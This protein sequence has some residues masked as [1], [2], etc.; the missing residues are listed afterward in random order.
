MD[1]IFIFLLGFLMSFNNNKQISILFIGNSFTY[2]NEM[3]TIFQEI[4]RSKGKDVYVEHCTQG[5]AT[6]LIQSNREEV[7]QSIASRK[8]D[9]I[10]IQGSSR[11]LLKNSS[12]LANKS[13]PALKKILRTIDKTNPNAKKLF[14]M[15]WAYHKGYKPHK[16]ADTYPKMTQKVKRGYLMLKNMFDIDIIPVGIAWYNLRQNNKKIKLYVKDG[17]HPSL[18]GSYL[19]ACCFYSGI[20]GDDATGSKYFSKLGPK[21]CRTLQR[22]ASS[23]V[24]G[25]QKRYGLN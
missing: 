2:R 5:K 20:F 18:K 24:L 10:V 7:H 21:T 16:E 23:T 12:A 19:A 13:I 4:A 3:P 1:L 25:Q 11:D 9:Y 8:W 14:F 17:A 22:I 15:T 6:F